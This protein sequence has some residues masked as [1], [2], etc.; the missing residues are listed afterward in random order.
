MVL[1]TPSASLARSSD[2]PNINTLLD[3]H[4]V[5]KYEMVDRI[6]LNA[7]V[8]KLQEPDQLHWFLCQHRGQ[9]IPRYELLGKITRDFVAAVEEYAQARQI[10]SV[11]FEK[12]QRKEAIAEPHFALAARSQRPGVV[13]IGVA[14]EKANVFRP[15]GKGQRTVG[16]FGAGRNSVF[17]KHVY[18]YIW[19]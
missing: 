19:D 13:M 10:P 15:P 2:M 18:F 17:V 3:D 14:Q 9:E 11:Q 6:F 16:R 1:G 12:R 4:V 8:P 7:Y 5:L